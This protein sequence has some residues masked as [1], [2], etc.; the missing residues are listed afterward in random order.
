MKTLILIIFQILNVMALNGLSKTDC[1]SC[2]KLPNHKFCIPFENYVGLNGVANT[3]YCCNMTQHIPAGKTALENY[4]CAQLQKAH[5]CTDYI[6]YDPNTGF[7][8]D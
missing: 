5:L 6:T 3:G 4:P 8:K 2:F 7:A 1:N